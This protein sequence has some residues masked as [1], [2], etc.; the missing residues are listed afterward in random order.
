VLVG[1]SMGGVLAHSVAS[2]LEDAGAAPT[3]VVMI[4]T[5]SPEDQAATDRVFALVMT[6]ILGRDPDGLIDDGSWLAMGTYLR[7]LA[8]FRPTRIA[9]PTLLIRAGTPFGPAG[10]GTAWPVWRIGGDEVEIAADHFAL[11]ED[12]GAATAE[13]T[14]RWVGP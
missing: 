3:G 11:I 12:A 2:L 4:D 9:A 6:E 14:E 13:A 10:E 5:P 1:Y 8:E 7:L